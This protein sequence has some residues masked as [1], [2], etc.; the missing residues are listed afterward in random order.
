MLATA[1]SG[2][3]VVVVCSSGFGE[4]VADSSERSAGS[5]RSAA[6]EMLP[7][8]TDLQSMVDAALADATR[9]AGPG[10]A[11]PRLVRA[12]KVTWPDGSLGC[13]IQGRMYTTALVPGYR[14]HIQSGAAELD[15]HAAERGS[16]FLCPP[17]RATEPAP[18]SA[19]R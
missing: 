7:V 16:P 9:R 11:A 13:P 2:V 1:L 12:E 6:R 18:D 3:L 4:P 10:A 8:N 15:Y 19:I 14:I 17:G 5:L